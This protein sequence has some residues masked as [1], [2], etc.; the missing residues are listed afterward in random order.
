MILYGVF[1]RACACLCVHVSVLCLCVLCVILCDVVWFVVCAFVRVCDDHVR[2][3]CDVLWLCM[4]LR[5][6]LSV[7][8]LLNAFACF[9]CGFLCGVVC[10]CICSCC[11]CLYVNCA[12][13]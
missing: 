6:C 12:F 1:V 4:Y 9:L 11:L 10:C 13:V 2:V 3:M 7:C 8:V 5:W